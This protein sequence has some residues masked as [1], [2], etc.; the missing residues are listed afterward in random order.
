MTCPA[1]ARRGARAAC[2]AG[3]DLHLAFTGDLIGF[4]YG[5]A[6]DRRHRSTAAG[7]VRDDG[8]W[9]GTLWPGVLLPGRGDGPAAELAYASSTSSGRTGS[10][11]RSAT[12]R[13]SA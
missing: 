12:P 3:P 10:S 1:A 2:A 9:L 7:Y 8:A 11:I 4:L 6:V 5:D 13:R